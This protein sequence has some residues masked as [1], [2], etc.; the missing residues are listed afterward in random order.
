MESPLQLNL[1]RLEKASCLPIHNN[2]V[3]ANESLP[4][5]Y[6]WHLCMQS[7]TF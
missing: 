4:L 1:E 3:S 6:A 2:E 5:D 7:R